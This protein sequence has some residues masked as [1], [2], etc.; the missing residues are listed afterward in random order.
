[1]DLRWAPAFVTFFNLYL[2]LTIDVVVLIEL[3]IALL[4]WDTNL[5]CIC[6]GEA[7]PA[8]PRGFTGSSGSPVSPNSIVLFTEHSG[9]NNDDDN[10]TNAFLW[11][12][13]GQSGLQGERGS[14]G[15]P[16]TKVISSYIEL[17]IT[18]G[19]AQNA[20]QFV[21]RI[22]PFTHQRRCR[23]CMGTAS[24]SR[25]FRVRCLP[26]AGRSRRS[27]QQPSSRQTTLLSLLSHCYFVLYVHLVVQWYIIMLTLNT[28]S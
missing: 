28:G 1:M 19:T 2:C 9:D 22:N 21:P 14:V 3:Q 8:G 23:P 18:L 4:Q 16:G 6:K 27:N 17:F 11:P 10:S 12:L 13:Q 15:L 20:L 24:A 7:G 25:A 5:F 26:L